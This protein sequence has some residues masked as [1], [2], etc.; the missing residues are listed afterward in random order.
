MGS[1]PGLKFSKNRFRPRRLSTGVVF[2]P[3]SPVALFFAIFCFRRH[4]CPPERVG[5]ARIKVFALDQ[6]LGRAN[7]RTA[8]DPKPH[9][10]A[11]G[12]TRTFLKVRSG[13]QLVDGARRLI[14][15]QMRIGVAAGVGIG[16]GNAT[17][18]LPR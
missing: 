17:G 4:G 11:L 8:G 7:R 2:S 16:D 14:D 5:Q 1:L 6:K 13:Q 9:M 10:S 3:S 18:R 15:S 12:P